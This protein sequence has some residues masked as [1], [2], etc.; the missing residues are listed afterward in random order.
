MYRF[1]I[2]D[3]STPYPVSTI[4][5]EPVGWDAV[6]LHFRR[7]TQW[8]GFFD[9]MDAQIMNWYGEAYGILKTAFD[10]VGVDANVLLK[11]EYACSETDVYS[12][13]W[14]GQFDFTQ[15]KQSEGLDGCYCSVPVMTSSCLYSFKNRTDQPVDLNSL[16]SFDSLTDGNFELTLEQATAVKTA[17]SNLV[18][19]L[20]ELVAEA[21]NDQTTC[22]GC[23]DSF[24]ILACYY[25]VNAAINAG[26]PYLEGSGAENEQYTVF[27]VFI[28]EAPDAPTEVAITAARDAIE[29]SILLIPS[30]TIQDVVETIFDYI[31]ANGLSG[32]TTTAAT[33]AKSFYSDY[34]TIYSANMPTANMAQYEYL[35]FQ[36]P[37]LSKIITYSERWIGALGNFGD[38]Y[39]IPM[40]ITTAGDDF[41]YSPVALAINFQLLWDD[42]TGGENSTAHTNETP[43]FIARIW[44]VPNDGFYDFKTDFQGTFTDTLYNS[45]DCGGSTATGDRQLLTN[46]AFDDVITL[47]YQIV[48]GG[49]AVA[50]V[51]I[52]RITPTLNPWNAAS[53]TFP[54][55]I[56]D[57]RTVNL[58]AGDV[59]YWYWTF[60]YERFDLP[61]DQ[62]VQW[63]FAYTAKDLYIS[64]D[65]T[66]PD[67]SGKVFAVNEAASRI[68][69]SIT[70][71][72]L[73]VYSDYFGRV[74]AQPYA[75]PVDG[76]G[77]LECIANGRF[78]RNATIANDGT[79][80]TNSISFNDLFKG[81][82]AIHNIGMGI[83]SDPMRAGYKRLR[84]EK[85]EYFYQYAVILTCDNVDNTEKAHLTKEDVGVFSFG[86]PNWQC[87]EINGLDE[88][89]TERKYRTTLQSID[90]TKDITCKFVTSGYAIEFTRRQGGG[91]SDWRYDDNT[92]LICLHRVAEIGGASR[93]ECEGSTPNIDFGDSKNIL[94]TTAYPNYNIRISP[95]RVLLNHIKSIF[96]TYTNYVD[97]KMFFTW[98]SGNY[99]ATVDFIDTTGCSQGI[100][101]L[102]EN[103]PIS[104]DNIDVPSDYYPQFSNDLVKFSYP[105]SATDF[106]AI[107]ANPYGL[108]EYSVNNGAYRYGWIEE[109]IWSPEEGMGDFTL[110][111]KIT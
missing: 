44:T 94:A 11:V 23:P 85:E 12:E 89:Q 66:F 9:F 47:A 74:D 22:S 53:V 6:T 58:Q 4:V 42:L 2:I 62:S 80:A 1:T 49:S 34:A 26:A 35:G 46:G 73:R 70:G 109:F 55:S 31:I 83:E 81:L 60:A 110:R 107:Q 27:G 98:G 25:A 71:G 77:G 33:A 96:R 63:N 59:I 17:Y 76:C 40:D 24:A 56:V 28:Q 14:T 106:R 69:E 16:V 38:A 15:Y 90:T 36:L 10:T 30:Y 45:I 43:P 8:H 50:T 72:C 61:N 48:R 97:G 32:A 3:N 100:E 78:I 54:F 104:Y 68:A 51:E 75:S 5:D 103:Q 86:Y 93:I 88:V 87:W 64:Q 57:A 84:I 91:S 18:F 92:F 37:L 52:G 29:A 101:P 20:S 99:Q 95:I 19:A 111:P 82:N 21:T 67:S 79:L 7:D 102:A 108:I 105:T 39:C 41:I 13:L 65:T